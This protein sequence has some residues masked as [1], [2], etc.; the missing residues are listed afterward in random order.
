MA[1]EF[2]YYYPAKVLGVDMIHFER[3]VPFHWRLRT[4]FEQFGCE[5][6]GIAF[7]NVPTPGV[8]R[9]VK[10]TWVDDDTLEVRTTAKTPRGELTET[11]RYHR[12]NQVGSW[13]GR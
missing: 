13:S 11:S 4:T 9:E 10:E 7:F 6:W 1:P 3:E 5:G 2:W 12:A 8:V